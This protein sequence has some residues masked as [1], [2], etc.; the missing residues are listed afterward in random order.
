MTA[1][2][3]M[4]FATATIAETVV[5]YDRNGADVGTGATN[6][7]NGAAWGDPSSFSKPAKAV[8]S[9]TTT[10]IEGVGNG[11]TPQVF[12]YNVVDT[13]TGVD[14][15]FTVA[16][17]AFANNSGSYEP[18]NRRAA[19]VDSPGQESRERIE[20]LT[21]GGFSE[22]VR[23]AFDP[24]SVVINTPGYNVS[25]AG[26]KEVNL[27]SIGTSAEGEIRESGSTNAPGTSSLA[28]FA[29]AD[30]G[31]QVLSLAASSATSID[32]VP[33]AGDQGANSNTGG[34]GFQAKGFVMS[35]DVTQGPLPS[36]PGF[37]ITDVN[38]DGEQAS[39]TWPSNPAPQNYK[40]FF[41]PDLI[42]W[43]ELDDSFQSQGTSSTY[44]DPIAE[45][46]ATLELPLPPK[47]FYR[48][49]ESDE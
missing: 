48:V 9:V 45:R 44:I 17:T 33:T 24:D 5:A 28:G 31:A 3:I 14:F 30:G 18:T 41:S 47:G 38:Y 46:Y 29:A 32:W 12:R 4:I 13:T 36:D 15:D 22:Y 26:W 8:D 42:S 39:V 7:A 21:A 27:T 20:F 43:E 34:F 16:F 23:T 37:K 1:I 11:T 25:F 2:A 6:P 35:F 49:Q 19:S 10:L 40:V